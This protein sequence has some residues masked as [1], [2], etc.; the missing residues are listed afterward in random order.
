V[1]RAARA[2]DAAAVARI[3]REARAEAMPWLPVMHTPEEDLAYFATALEG[4]AFV[5]E[6]AGEMLGYVVLRDAEL[7]HLYVA[8]DAQGRGVG[9]ALFDMARRRRTAGFELW[10]FRDNDRARAFYEARGCRVVRET[11]GS[12]NEEGVPDALYEWRPEHKP[13]R[14]SVLEAGDDR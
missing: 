4:E 11:D 6:D 10:V 8:P 5:F 13:D 7:Q 3:H 14:A 1:I 9:S 12:D 2:E